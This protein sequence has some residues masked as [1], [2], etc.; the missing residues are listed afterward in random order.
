[1]AENKAT[2]LEQLRALAERGKL[3]TLNRVDQLLESI[4]PLLEGAQHSG[5]TVTLPAENWSGRAQTVKDNILLADEKFIRLRTNSFVRYCL[6]RN[7]RER[8]GQKRNDAGSDIA[9]FVCRSDYRPEQRRQEP[10]E[11]SP[12]SEENICCDV[13]T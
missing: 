11:D 12:A 4:I 9:F 1:M 10:P 13:P 2:T 6:K 5:T 3:D 7:Q 8:K